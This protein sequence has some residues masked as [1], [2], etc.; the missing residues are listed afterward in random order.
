MVGYRRLKLTPLYKLTLLFRHVISGL[1]ATII[2]DPLSIQKNLKISDDQMSNCHKSNI[3]TRGN[4][5]G[6]TENPL[7][8]TGQDVP[9]KGIPPGFE[10]RGIVALVFSCVAA[11]IGLAII[12]WYGYAPLKG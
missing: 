11:F 2:E 7:D 4:A 3:L 8:L 12:S 5:A 1:S 10:A 9:P 6:N